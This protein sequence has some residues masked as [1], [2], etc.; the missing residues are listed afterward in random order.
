M[1]RAVRDHPGHHASVHHHPTSAFRSPPQAA[2]KPRLTYHHHKQG[3]IIPRGKTA[4]ATSCD[5]TLADAGDEYLFSGSTDASSS[6]F[7]LTRDRHHKLRPAA[8]FEA[9]QSRRTGPSVYLPIWYS[10]PTLE[11]FRKARAIAGDACTRRRDDFAPMRPG[12][13]ATYKYETQEAYYAQYANSM[14]A[15]TM[16]KAGLDSMRHYE[17]LA[18]GS[19][20]YF[21]GS[22]ALTA[23]PLTMYAFPRA[24]V[25]AA[26]SLPGVP[27]EAHV[28]EA[29]QTDKP[30]SINYSIFDMPR[31]CA[32][33]AQL[34][35]HTERYLTTRTL[36]SYVLE[37]LRHAVPS[38]LPAG[39]TP[40]VLMITSKGVSGDTWQNAFLYHGLV[41]LL[42]PRFSS[43][44]GR[45]EVLYED[46]IYPHRFCCYGR[47]YSYARTLH[48]PPIYRQCSKSFADS[49]LR[50][51]VRRRLEF[52]Y[53]N[54]I[55][56]TTQ[57]NKCCQLARCYG[58][59]IPKLI[60]AYI[61]RRGNATAVAT[62]DGSDGFGGCGGATF[63]ELDRIDAHFL[64]EVDSRHNGRTARLV[65]APHTSIIP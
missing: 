65:R 7:G 24:A 43:Y 2:V 14:Y 4:S 39:V 17:I 23:N 56:V 49:T 60:N 64:R 16:P 61:K 25:H 29:L 13:I 8:A 31:F 35:A 58:D 5:T 40:R 33:R 11:A 22:A 41:Q 63:G 28:A 34:I 55:I 44:L 21:V 26:S 54:V 15:I 57:A 36:A 32:L 51:Q 38:A 12:R 52:G 20:P 59:E 1:S 19:V 50:N 46:F 37:Q 3:H 30:L 45:K 47:G 48:T 18:S 27:A 53:F 6:L 10:L 62:V 9:L 42:G